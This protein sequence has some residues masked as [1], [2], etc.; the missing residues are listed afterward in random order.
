MSSIISTSVTYND[1][2]F[3]TENF[4]ASE[5][6]A[7]VQKKF[8]IPD[9]VLEWTSVPYLTDCNLLISILCYYNY[10]NVSEQFI[11]DVARNLGEVAE[12]QEY[13]LAELPLELLWLAIDQWPSLYYSPNMEKLCDFSERKEL[14]SQRN[15]IGLVSVWR[16]NKEQ[17]ENTFIDYCK[18]GNYSMAKYLLPSNLDELKEGYNMSCLCNRTEIVKLIIPLLHQEKELYLYGIKMAILHINV[19]LFNYFRSIMDNSDFKIG[20]M[21]HLSE[22]CFYENENERVPIASI[23]IASD[24]PPAE[25]PKFEYLSTESRSFAKY[26]DARA[27]RRDPFFIKPAGEAD[28]CNIPVPVRAVADSRGA[29]SAPRGALR[30]AR[31]YGVRNEGYD[32][33]NDGSP[34]AA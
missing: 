29:G 22:I 23:R 12:K 10:L 3:D 17:L 6:H 24:L 27:N 20:C 33:R 21:K 13:N 15:K 4:N 14:Y 30:Q 18:Y 32:V 5:W 26:A 1:C 7:L 16:H 34:S 11:N 8:N 9:E 25:Q 28:I 31:G 2:A 19:E